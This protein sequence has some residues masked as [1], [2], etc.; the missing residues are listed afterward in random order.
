MDESD[1]GEA[2]GEMFEG[3][4]RHRGGLRVDG[5]Q[6]VVLAQFEIVELDGAFFAAV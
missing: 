6:G 4:R 3:E 1:G 2:V 5:E